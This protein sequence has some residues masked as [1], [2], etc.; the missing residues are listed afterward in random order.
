MDLGKQILINLLFKI[1]M[2]SKNEHDAESDISI[3][4]N[5]VVRYKKKIETITRRGPGSGG[6]AC[7]KCF[8][9]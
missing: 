6:D 7:F 9:P 2:D 1:I 3:I 5:A 4:S 8:T